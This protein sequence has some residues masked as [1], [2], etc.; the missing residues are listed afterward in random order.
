MLNKILSINP[1]MNFKGKLIKP[2]YL[3]NWYYFKDYF[4]H[5]FNLFESILWDNQMPFMN[6]V[7]CTNI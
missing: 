5:S 3:I 4:T 6:W 2:I 1:N 7:S